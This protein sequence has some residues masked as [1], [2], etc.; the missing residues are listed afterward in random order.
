MI[1]INDK[2]IWVMSKKIWMPFLSNSKPSTNSSAKYKLVRDRTANVSIRNVTIEGLEKNDG[3]ETHDDER[4]A[5]PADSCLA[6]RSRKIV[7]ACCKTNVNDTEELLKRKENRARAEQQ[8][9]NSEER[10]RL[11]SDEKKIIK[12]EKTSPRK[13]PRKEVEVWV[14][15]Q[16]YNLEEQPR[17]KSVEKKI[18]KTEELSARKKPHKEAEVREE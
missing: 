9:Q 2:M 7:R 13:N 11:K 1:D 8:H 3:D 10:R 6:I 16:R 14:G 15:E 5:F 18:I 17:S 4:V 12:T